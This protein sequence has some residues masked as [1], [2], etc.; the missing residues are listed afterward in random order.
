MEPTFELIRGKSPAVKAEVISQ[1]SRG[2]QSLCMFRVMYDHSH[3]SA[4]EYYAWIS[5]MLAI[6][7][8]WD[9]VIE[10]IRFFE[11]SGMLPLL[12]DTRKYLEDR[13]RRRGLEWGEAVL[14]DP[15]RDPEL[16][17]AIDGFYEQFQQTGPV[18]HA[19]IA[20]YIRNH[21]EEYVEL[22]D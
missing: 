2:Q 21:P 14:S 18:T 16:R 20:D 7:G 9:R 8:Y 5:Y 3:K 4:N 13:N 6:P 10:G 12:E 1:L 15:D 19:V 11:T 17:Q 22:T